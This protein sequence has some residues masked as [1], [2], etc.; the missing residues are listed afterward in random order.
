MAIDRIKELLKRFNPQAS[1]VDIE[2]LAKALDSSGARPRAGAAVSEEELA[3]RKKF[4]ESIG[5]TNRARQEELEYIE[6]EIAKTRA[7][8]EAQIDLVA[9]TK[10]LTQAQEDQ[11]EQTKMPTLNKTK[12]SK[13]QR[14]LRNL[15]S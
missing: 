13:P 8:V 6:S 11:N 1:D 2:E 14:P 7:A 12:M 3:Q 10:D 9:A 15:K 4:L 5:E